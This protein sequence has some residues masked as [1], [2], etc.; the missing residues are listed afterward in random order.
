MSS[1][2]RSWT[3][4]KYAP[5]LLS[6]AEVI[7][8]LFPTTIL[9]ISTQKFFHVI[10]VSRISASASELSTLAK[11]F[12][13]RRISHLRWKAVSNVK[14]FWSD[15]FIVPMMERFEGIRTFSVFLSL[16]YISSAIFIF[17]I[18]Y[19]LVPMGYPLSSISRISTLRSS[20]WNTSPK[21]AGALPRLISSIIRM[22]SLLG[23]L[24]DSRRIFVKGPGVNL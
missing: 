1:Y 9:L 18:P 12:S 8:V 4:T 17:V 3:W 7:L 11:S 14:T 22:Y 23:L 6:S 24:Y 20:N 13:I 10:P 15:V 16:P 2:L 5:S 19:S 21:I